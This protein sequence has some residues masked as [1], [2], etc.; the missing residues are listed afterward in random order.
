MALSGSNDDED[1]AD[2]IVDDFPPGAPGEAEEEEVPESYVCGSC[3]RF[4]GN[5]RGSGGAERLPSLTAVESL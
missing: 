4:V 2:S 3:V 5:V 1:D